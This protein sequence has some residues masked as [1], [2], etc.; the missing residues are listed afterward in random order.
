[1]DKVIARRDF[2]DNSPGY[3]PMTPVATV[4][5]NPVPSFD[6]YGA[7][8]R[9]KS[10]IILLAVLG[11]GLAGL[12][13]WFSTP[14]YA[15]VLRLMIW[16]QAPPSVINGEVVQQQVALEKQKTLL[17]S[18]T[19]LSAAMKSLQEMKDEKGESLLATFNELD[20]SLGD[21]GEMLTVSPVGKDMSSDSLE[22]RCEGKHKEDLP[23]ILTEVYKSYEKVIQ[24]NSSESG[25]DTIELLRNLQDSLKTENDKSLRDYQ[26]MLAD[27]T[28]VTENQ[29]GKWVNPHVAELNRMTLE[30]DEFLKSFREADQSLEQI[31][32]AVDPE[33]TNEDLLRLAVIEAKKYF[34][35]V[36]REDGY[37]LLAFEDRQRVSRYEQRIEAGYAEVLALEAEREESAKRFGEK[38]PQVEFV[39][40]K[41]Q[42]ALAAMNRLNK[43]LDGLRSLS[44]E[45]DPKA[46]L[47]ESAIQEAKNRDEQ[48]VR[49]YA[50][51][52]MNQRERAKYN[53][54]KAND[55]IVSKEKLTNKTSQQI[56]QLNL[57]REEIDDRRAS[58]S[59]ILEQMAAIEVTSGNYASTKV[60]LIDHATSPR[61]VFPVLW[62]FL[63]VGSLIGGFLGCGLAIL[64]D[65]SDLSYR[66]PIDIQESLNV[67]VICKVPKIRKGKLD[68][69]FTG[70]PMLITCLNSNSSAAETFRAA[71]TSLLFAAGQTG[72][73]V[74]MFTSPSPGDGK[75]T[76]VANLAISLAQTNK[77]ICLIDA[78]YRRPR[79]Q[80]NFGIQF[81]PGGMQYLLGEATLAEVLRPCDFQSN[82]TVMTTGG[83][84]HNP[85]ELIASSAFA[86]MV[87]E[88]RNQFDIVLIDCPPIIP[89]A[90]AASLASVVDG[91][92]MILRIRRGVILSAHKAKERLDMVNGNLMGVIVNGMD[93]NLYYNEYGTY[94]RGAYYSGTNYSK[95]Y[96]RQY[97]DYSDKVRSEDRK[98][99]TSRS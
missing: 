73:K 31:Q 67:P 7:L 77:K 68:K 54:D 97:S 21:L 30:R 38:H 70:S 57:L 99:V 22:I 85:G 82:L 2:E 84:P 12:L 10:V 72:H 3:R 9:R 81:E 86:D 52:L 60:R 63:L 1:M 20:F 83:R 47:N 39:E 5:E 14:T 51:A 26:A 33:T 42:A 23:L 16:M 95:Y 79:V 61:Q 56:A 40:S 89:V 49:M 24:G 90:D 65:H 76:I 28:L 46:K 96:D 55:D 36:G 8:W 37:S 92:I 43:E 41:Y 71:R 13:F 50:A 94:Y 87:G 29:L 80:Q 44:S 48:M 35:L 6:I 34:N 59:Q 98:R 78:D 88:L 19:V 15:S 66:T 91:I 4:E 62:K 32:A 45:G 53:L 74:F 69:D 11:A 27:L 58:L 17:S 18:E 25:R 64:I 93:E 75:S